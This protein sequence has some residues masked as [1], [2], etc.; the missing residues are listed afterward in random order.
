MKTRMSMLLVA[1]LGA[2]VLLSACATVKGLGRDI[3][4]V[5]QAGE[6]AIN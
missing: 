4:S 1:V 2:S 3:E 6:E 5:G